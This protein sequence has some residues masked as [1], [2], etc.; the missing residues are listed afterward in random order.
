MYPP[1]GQHSV[2]TPIFKR[3]IEI[4]SNPEAFT[5]MGTAQFDARLQTYHCYTPA[6]YPKQYKHIA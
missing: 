6:L 1:C 5:T 4:L 2:S 3:D